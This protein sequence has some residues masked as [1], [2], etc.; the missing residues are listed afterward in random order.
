MFNPIIVPFF[1]KMKAS[2]KKD[3]LIEITAMLYVFLFIYAAVS[4]LS[5]IDQ[6][7][8]QMQQ[9]SLLIPYAHFLVWIIPI[10]E[11]CISV[12]LVVSA[13]RLFAFYASFS[14]MIIF[15]TYIIIILNFSEHI[16]C[17]CGGILSALGWEQH[18]VLNTSFVLLGL[19]GIVMQFEDAQ[20][21]AG[22]SR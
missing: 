9:S 15:T 21:F 5:D 7:R 17:S 18:L 4:K 3:F 10:V 20:R 11:I 22:G 6:F 2:M 16:P 19:A 12:L 8:V 14:L 13:T 1:R